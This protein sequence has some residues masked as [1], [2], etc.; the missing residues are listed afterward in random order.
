MTIYLV[1][2]QGKEGENEGDDEDDKIDGNKYNIFFEERK[3]IMKKSE[4]RKDADD[5]S[6]RIELHGDEEDG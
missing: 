4:R 6:K 2:L 1:Y 3:M 5:E